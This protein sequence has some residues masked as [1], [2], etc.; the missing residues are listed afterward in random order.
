M[1]INP[2]GKVADRLTTGADWNTLYYHE[3]PTPLLETT[4]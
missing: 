4:G 1:T 3:Q 2:K